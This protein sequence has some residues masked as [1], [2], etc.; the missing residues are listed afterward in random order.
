MKRTIATVGVGLAGLAV[1][2]A[3][4][5]GNDPGEGNDSTENIQLTLWHNFYA[6]DLRSI[7]MRG[8]I[9]SYEEQYPNVELHVRAINPDDYRAQILQAAQEDKLPDVFVM[10]SGAMT[11]G[12][13]DSGVIQPINSLLDD[14]PEWRDGFLPGSME[15]FTED[16]DTYSAP[17]GLSPTSILYYNK[18]IFLE[19]KLTVPR[20]WEEL[21]EVSR[22]LNERGI[23]PIALGNKAGWLAQSSI[24]SSL[25]DRVTGTSWFMQAVSGEGASFMDP[26]FVQALSYM[27]ELG[28]EDVFQEGYEELDNLEME[29]LFA[30]GGAAMMIDGGWALTNLAANA[31]TEELQRIGA[32]VLPTMPEGKGDPRTLSGAIGS[33]MGL[34]SKAQGE[35]REAALRLIYAM[36]GPDAQRRTLES[37]QLV[38]YKIDLD[39]NKVSPIFAEV[40][41]LVN[42]VS[43]TPVYD[44][45]MSR[46]AADVL[47]DGLKRLLAGE[48]EPEEI[49]A[50]LQ[51]T[52]E[53]VS[54]KQ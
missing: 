17:M 37:N 15:A 51:A 44:G 12:F 52:M 1:L 7:M 29:M 8:I 33:G 13:A 49:A 28:Q 30:R 18:S 39:R 34:S 5:M 45:Y 48:A 26:E 21:I 25:A 19:Q 2:A 4:G 11:K 16:D 14:Y 43:L 24:F 23:A 38:S 53:K 22:E 3:C 31:K 40:Y 50:A 47:N 32:T 35:T 42:S 10:W 6:E 9:E 20:T 27:K 41:E 36:S 54:A 46:E